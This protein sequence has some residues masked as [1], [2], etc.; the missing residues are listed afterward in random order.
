MLVSYAPKQRKNVFV[1]SP[2]HDTPEV[3]EGHRNQPIMIQF[4]NKTKG[5]VDAEYQMI[6]V[7]MA[8][9]WVLDVGKWSSFTPLLISVP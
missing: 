2:M 4:Y 1:Q 7:C 6:D 9:R 8:P 5:S 3:D